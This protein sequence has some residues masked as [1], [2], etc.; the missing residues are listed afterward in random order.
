MLKLACL[1]LSCLHSF[2]MLVKRLERTAVL[3]SCRASPAA[4]GG[5]GEHRVLG[6]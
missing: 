6:S 4:A 5:P 3:V 2:A 1:Q